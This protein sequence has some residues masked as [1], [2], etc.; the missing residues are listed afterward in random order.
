MGSVYIS[1]IAT[2]EGM[3]EWF[4]TMD[5]SSATILWPKAKQARPLIAEWCQAHHIA[6]Y[7]VDVYDTIHLQP[8]VPIDG[9]DEIVFTSPSTVDA[10]FAMWP[11]LPARIRLT[12]I[13]PVTK[14][15]LVVRYGRKM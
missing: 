14:E 2:Q 5:L 9:V 15:R 6:L 13:G 3:I 11:E 10:L 1:P 7:S 12:P 4:Q 8:N